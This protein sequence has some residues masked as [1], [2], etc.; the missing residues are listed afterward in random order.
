MSGMP[1]VKKPY[2]WQD[3]QTLPEGDRW[4]ILDGEPYAMSPTPTLRHQTIL[5]ELGAQVLS[6][7]RGQNCRPII[8]PFDVKFDD[9]N[10]TEPDLMIVCDPTQLK[11]N[12]VEG[13]P[14]LA[15]EIVSDHGIVR[16]RVHKMRLYARCGVKEY[17]II[18]P[19]PP[20]IEVFLLDGETYRVAGSYRKEDA[21]RSP[22]FPK[23]K[24]DL[25]VIFD[26][27]PGP[28]DVVEV[29]KEPPGRYRT[30]SRK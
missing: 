11:S 26:Y 30:K 23:L 29:V 28:G 20:M 10:C 22:S 8:A 18:T 5:M 15:V 14:A 19:W 21:F 12:H 27:P 1:A 3:Y 6:Q 4:E 17:W 9:I 7:F 13:A 2:T 24:L 16:D 25:K